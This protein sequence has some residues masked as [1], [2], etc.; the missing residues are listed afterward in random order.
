V[1]R[2]KSF[3]IFSAAAICSAIFL[4]PT[5]ALSQS[6]PDKEDKA[7][8]ARQGYMKLVVWEAGPLFGMAKGDMAYN[9]D[10]AKARAANLKAISLYPVET[11]FLPGTSNADRPDKTRSLPAIWKDTV[12]VTKAYEQWRSA[13][14]GVVDAAGKGQSELATAVGALGKSCGACHKPYR[15]K[16]S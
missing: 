10:M 7:I 13:I 11:L 12:G 9:A 2:S 6:K 5:M 15:A 3:K 8:A 14:D 4:V 16:K 1:T